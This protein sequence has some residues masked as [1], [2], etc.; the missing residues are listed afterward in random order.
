MTQTYYVEP[1]YWIS[2]YAQ[3]DIFEASAV[4][5]LD[6][7]ATAE[8]LR[9]QSV[10]GAAVAA[11]TASA[12][13]TRIQHS[14]SAILAEL[15]ASATAISVKSAASQLTAALSVSAIAN[16]VQHSSASAAFSVI[17]SANAR[18]L[19]EPEPSAT[20]IWTEQGQASSRPYESFRAHGKNCARLC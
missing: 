3:G 7:T 18:F 17:V 5:S 19:W 12:L 8:V 14:A 4:V 16:R 1:D 10:A 20:D 2:G 9:V 13:A 15:T 11:L 6:M